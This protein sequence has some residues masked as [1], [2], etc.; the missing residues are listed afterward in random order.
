MK[1]LLPTVRALTVWALWILPYPGLALAT[2]FPPLETGSQTVTNPSS[3]G[4]QGY[5]FFVKPGGFL[6]QGDIAGVGAGTEWR[7]EILGI[8]L[9]QIRGGEFTNL[10]FGFTNLDFGGPLPS[11]GIN[12]AFTPGND[13]ITL[14][15]YAGLSLEQAQGVSQQHLH[16]DRLAGTFDLA[17]DFFKPS[18]SDPWSVSPF[19]RGALEGTDWALFSG[20]SFQSQFHGDFT[21]GTLIVAFSHATGSVSFENYSLFAVPPPTSPVPEPSTWLLFGSGLAGLALWRMRR[22]VGTR[23]LP[24]RLFALL[25]RQKGRSVTRKRV[26]WVRTGLFTLLLTLIVTSSALATTY[27]FTTLD[28]PGASFSVAYGINNAGQ[29]VGEV[30]FSDPFQPIQRATRWDG[31]TATDLGTLG[32][33]RAFAYD[34]NNA[35]QVVG[36]SLTSGDAATHATRWDGGTATDLGTFLGGALGTSVAYGINDAGQVVGYSTYGSGGPHAT[37]WDGGTLTDL[38]FGSASSA[39]G[40][41]NAGQITG[42]NLPP[43]FLWDGG[44]LTNLGTLG[45]E[46]TE[47][48]GINDAGQVVGYSEI[49]GHIQ[50][51][52]LWDGGTMTNLGTLGLG[53]GT[54]SNA[55]AINNA[56]Q[57]VGY[58]E[59]GQILH[60]FLWSGNSIIDLNSLVDSSGAG[61]TLE[62]ANDINDVGQIVGVAR[63]SLGQQRAFLLTPT[64]PVPE[65]S[66]WLLFGSGLVG[67]VLWRRK[68]AA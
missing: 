47:A 42:Y 5:Q 67:L 38:G 27:T 40:I 48:R 14:N 25:T 34:I 26:A 13:L 30:E 41:N 2:T 21:G 68:L 36:W 6:G 18:A 46:T 20:G 50:G 51:A 63:N 19:A 33:A 66:T 9:T 1:L 23:R 29:V 24:L 55:N 58:S 4:D 11:F 17:Y 3:A 8:D 61:W 16:I 54:F 45:G 39:T 43:S 64:S 12:V 7:I 37:R 62:N 52:F 53:G 28:A 65:P 22:H 31:G 57:V 59:G 56:G 49:S 10:D 60:A 15:S 35:G 32:G 44:T